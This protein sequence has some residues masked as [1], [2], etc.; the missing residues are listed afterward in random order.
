[1]ETF[2][3]SILS[4][5]KKIFEA[6]AQSLVAPAITGYAGILAHHAP[7]MTMLVPGRITLREKSGKTT[8]LD[9]Q[10]SGFLEV[11]QN[12]AVLLVGSAELAP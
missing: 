6:Q 12:R 5:D 11:S 2:G 3:V 7:Y 4:A 8:T 10:G 9:C 1:M